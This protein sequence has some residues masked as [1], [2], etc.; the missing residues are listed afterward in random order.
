MC[1]AGSEQAGRDGI[2]HANKECS[3]IEAMNRQLEILMQLQEMMLLR[4]AGELLQPGA[5]PEAYERL[6]ERIDRLRRKLPGPVIAHFDALIAEAPDAVAQLADGVC[7]GCH[8][9][10]PAKVASAVRY[11]KALAQCDHCG[12]FLFCASNAPRYIALK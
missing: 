10:L 6:D 12:R 9:V 8:Q 5:E 1:Q 7:L 4:K 3:E 2:G 11:S